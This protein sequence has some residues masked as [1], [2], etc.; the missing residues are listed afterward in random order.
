ML[1]LNFKNW[2]RLNDHPNQK[3]INQSK[4]ALL[5]P[6]NIWELVVFVL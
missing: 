1:E 4:T 6:R 2:K 5:D 3:M